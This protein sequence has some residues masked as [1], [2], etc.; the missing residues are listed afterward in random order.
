MLEEYVG[1]AGLPQRW[2]SDETLKTAVQTY[3]SQDAA[4]TQQQLE[5]IRQYCL[6]VIKAPCYY[7][8]RAEGERQ[9]LENRLEEVKTAEAL[10]HW[11]ADALQFGMDPF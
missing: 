7:E 6:Y 9:V 1:I 2:Q 8:S 3:F 5:T 4:I 10:Q 11:L